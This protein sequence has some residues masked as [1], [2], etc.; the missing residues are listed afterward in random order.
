MPR[1]ILVLLI[2]LSSVTFALEL[3]GKAEVDITQHLYYAYGSDNNET[4]DDLKN[5][6]WYRDTRSIDTSNLNSR[7]YWLKLTL[8]N[9]T[10]Q[11]HYYLLF[12]T[13]FIL[14][15]KA[16]HVVGGNII[17]TQSDG[18][19]H[20]NKDR[21]N[22]SY[23]LLLPVKIPQGQTLEIYFKINNVML[24][25]PTTLI[26]QEHLSTFNT[27]FYLL[28]GA[29][30]GVL[31]VFFLFYFVLYIITNFKAYLY[32]IFYIFGL[33]LYYAHYHGFSNILP[34]YQEYGY[35]LSYLTFV[36]GAIIYIALAYF[37]KEMLLLKQR[38]GWANNA[39]TYITIYMM[40][41]IVIAA[42]FFLTHNHYLAQ[43]SF[44]LFYLVIPPYII[45][46]IGSAYYL[47]YQ[48]DRSAQ[49]IAWVW[50]LMIASAI[51]AFLLPQ[52]NIV[53]NPNYAYYNAVFQ[54]VIMVEVILF[55]IILA[56]RI[57]EIEKQKEQQKE[58]LI[59]Q[60]KLASMGEMIAIIAHQWK[61]PLSVVAIMTEILRERNQLGRLD[62]E[63]IDEKLTTIDSNV[64]QMSV[65]I[66]DFLSYFNPQKQKNTFLLKEAVDKT[67]IIL[68]QQIEQS[69]ITLSIDIDKNTTLQ[70]YRD[71]YVQVLISIISNAID[72]FEEQENK[73]ITITME[74]RV[75]S[76]A[77]NAGGIN[78]TVMGNIFE[79]YFSTK[80][81]KKGTGLGL[82]IAKM[83]IE[84][85]GG[86]LNAHNNT[87]GAIFSITIPPRD[88]S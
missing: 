67:L 83:I 86:D 64:T 22:G 14:S 10:A 29:F 71:E 7:P 51:V 5:I 50:S 24:Y 69:G 34:I 41:V 75:L 46:V 65:T 55:S 13:Q 73:S 80:E 37:M 66:N 59:Y 30:F 36:G 88:Q 68:S 21:I 77:D 11:E 85:M 25:I 56:L 44:Q 82:Y 84:N 58:M 2:V 16:Y 63:I 18:Y 15:L 43:K 12:G 23:R 17:K 3:K 60:S 52:L 19:W 1:Y 76:I 26:T 42:Y 45:I 79:P 70:G 20:K 48:G 54:G 87:Q 38:I 53:R 28:Q 6:P 32:Y 40:A 27:T 49:Y 72:A 4:P 62:S 47:A 31:I 9:H 35:A 57:K 74:G 81:E 8:T 39:L 33:I 61:Q 78:P